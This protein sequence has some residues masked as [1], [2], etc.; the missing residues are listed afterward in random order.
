M[1]AAP[2]SVKIVSTQWRGAHIMKRREACM[3]ELGK[4]VSFD[5]ITKEQRDKGGSYTGG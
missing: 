4:I 2:I 5:I 3:T 1:N